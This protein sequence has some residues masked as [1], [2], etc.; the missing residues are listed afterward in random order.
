M[1]II[2]DGYLDRSAQRIGI[3]AI[4][5]ADADRHPRQIVQELARSLRDVTGGHIQDIATALY[6]DWYG[7]GDTR[8]ATGGASRARAT[9]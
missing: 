8:A 9:G 7:P 3:E 1:L 6:L 5:A 4:F 2:T